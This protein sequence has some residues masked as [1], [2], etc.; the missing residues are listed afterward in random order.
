VYVVSLGTIL[1]HAF[2]T[3]LAVI[4]GRYVSSKISVRHGE[5]RFLFFFVFPF[6]FIDTKRIVTL[7]GAVL[8]LLFGFIYLYEG[9]R[10]GMPSPSDHVPVSSDS[11]SDLLH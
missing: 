11:A 5:Y 8:F 9:L 2:C 6:S 1:G 10:L 7:G 4:G 3:A